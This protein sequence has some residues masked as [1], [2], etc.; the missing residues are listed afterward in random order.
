MAGISSR[1]RKPGCFQPGPQGGPQPC[2]RPRGPAGRWCAVSQL[3]VDVETPAWRRGS[4]FSDWSEVWVDHLLHCGNLDERLSRV[5][6]TAFC[7][8]ALHQRSFGVQLGEV[9]RLR[10]GGLG[11][12]FPFFRL[13]GH[14]SSWAS[15]LAGRF[16]LRVAPPF[17][18]LFRPFASFSP[19]SARRRSGRPGGPAAPWWRSTP[20]GEPRWRVVS[21]KTR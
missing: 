9:V 20:A 19:G 7:S 8:Q 1:G 5:M 21:V 12:W 6:S 4:A 11:F 17:Y 15:S 3:S 2:G 16:P 13:A 14:S 10:F 18:V